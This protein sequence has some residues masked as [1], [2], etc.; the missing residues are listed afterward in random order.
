MEWSFEGF[1]RILIGIGTTGSFG[2]LLAIFLRQRV[3]MQKLRDS[4][5]EAIRSDLLGEIEKLREEARKERR[6]CDERIKG[7]EA[8][9]DLEVRRLQ[10][11]IDGLQRQIVMQSTIVPV[12]LSAAPE[13][14]ENAREA[15]KRVAGYVQ[16]AVSQNEG[17]TNG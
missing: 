16:R 6:E 7:I 3:P 9:H 10:A 14:I 4:R 12:H 15:S 1:I 17:E 8:A 11:Q 13:A 2:T 5:E